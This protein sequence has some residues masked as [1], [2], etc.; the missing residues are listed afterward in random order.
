MSQLV[1]RG[2]GSFELEIHP[3]GIELKTVFALQDVRKIKYLDNTSPFCNARPRFEERYLG[4][5]DL[6]VYNWVLKI[7]FGTSDFQGRKKI[8]HFE[9]LAMLSGYT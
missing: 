1:T 3:R 8:M 9:N 5:L 7:L 4:Q 2:A 6:L